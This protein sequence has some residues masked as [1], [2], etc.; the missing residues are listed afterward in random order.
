MADTYKLT[1]VSIGYRLAPEDPW[2]RGVEDCY[3]AAEWL[4]ANSKAEFDGDLLYTG[5]EVS[6][7][8]H[9]L[10]VHGILTHKSVRRRASRPAHGA[11]PPPLAAQ[12]LLFR[13]APALWL[14]RPLVFSASRAPPRR[15]SRHR[16]RHHVLVPH[17]AP[18]QHDRRRAP[19]P[20]HQSVLGGPKAV[21]GQIA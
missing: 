11:P 1:V 10:P 17:C 5:G 6:T 9:T 2:P 21:S 16:P 18:P 13:S 3:D 8:Y 7:L 15:R 12:F 4:V 19:R 20:E 14:L